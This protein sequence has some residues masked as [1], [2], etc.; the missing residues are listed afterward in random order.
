MNEDVKK[1]GRRP[2][3]P[4]YLWPWGDQE[5]KTNRVIVNTMRA[6]HRDKETTKTRTG[7]GGGHGTIAQTGF[8]I[9]RTHAALSPIPPLT[10]HFY[11]AIKFLE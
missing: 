6:R 1:E 4:L 3:V 2:T 8:I 5:G 7:R 10:A 11:F 9:T